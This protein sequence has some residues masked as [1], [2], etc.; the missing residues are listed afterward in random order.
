MKL[1]KREDLALIFAIVIIVLFVILFALDTFGEHV[2]QTR[3]IIGSLILV[4]AG[5]L[6]GPKIIGKPDKPTDT[7]PPEEGGP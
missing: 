6:F 7:R 2:G 1:P 4:V 3:Y 5:Y